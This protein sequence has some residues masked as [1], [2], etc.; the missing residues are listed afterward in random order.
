MNKFTDYNLIK[1]DELY[2]QPLEI[3]WLVEDYIPSDSIGMLFGASGSGKSHIALSLAVSIAN[4]TKWFDQ[5][6]KE[7][8]VLI[9]AGEGNNGLQRRLKAIEAEHETTINPERIFFSERPIGLDTDEG[10]DDAVTAIDNL[11]RDLDLIV[12][13][14]LSRHL[15]KSAENSNDDMAQFI[16]RLEQLRHR[17]ECT[18]LVVH[19]TGK[20]SQQGARGASALKANID[21]SFAVQKGDNKICRLTCDKQKDA[22]DDLP[23]K[24]FLIKGVE[25][26]ETDTNGNAITGACI[27]E[28]N[29]MPS[30]SM[31]KG[32]D[33]EQLAIDTFNPEK[34]LWQEA[35]VEACEDKSK[36]DSKKKRFRGVID[37]LLGAGK[38][39]VTDDEC[40]VIDS[41]S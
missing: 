39:S 37:G 7:G 36:A 38:I 26:G 13:D 9:L 17:Y 30:I 4:G 12:I 18:V 29:D 8:D 19:H 1:L 23:A 20:S 3:D 15:L 2:S 5:R 24:H 21:F 32:I 16:N 11:G 10:F 33:Y 27:V 14:T 35:F 22:D 41:D 28:A 34:P 40:Y 25:L 6:T 31:T